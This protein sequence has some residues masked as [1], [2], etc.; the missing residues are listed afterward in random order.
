MII[1]RGYFSSHRI[2]DSTT[3][4]NEAYYRTRTFSASSISSASGTTVFISHKHD[5]L[6]DLKDFI[7]YLHKDY[8]IIPYIDSMDKGMPKNTCAETATRIKSV[9][10]NCQ[11]FIL[12]ATNKALYSKWCNWEVGIADKT[13]LPTN[14]MAILPMKDNNSSFF[15]G[16]E[17]LEI[18]PFIEEVIDI[19]NYRKYLAVSIHT[20]NGLKR[21]S[22]KDWLNNYVN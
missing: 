10:G 12:L 22:L 20:S 14:N 4:L 5:D 19:N 15:L 6:E 2:S 16:N 18:Y 21:I 7:S 11:K 9:I 17:Y 1:T 13:K 3:M 8:N